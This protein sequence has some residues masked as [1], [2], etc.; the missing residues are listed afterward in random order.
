MSTQ[1]DDQRAGLRSGLTS[2]LEACM[3]LNEMGFVE[4]SQGDHPS[5]VFLS[6]Y[7]YAKN[8]PYQELLYCR[9][10]E[11][12][13]TSLPLLNLED[14]EAFQWPGHMVLHLHWLNKVLDGCET[15]ESANH[16]TDAFIAQLRR[17]R[18]LGYHIIWSIHNVH[19]H[20]AKHPE[21]ESL[22]GQRMANE[23]DTVHVLNWNTLKE[24]EAYYT[25]DADKVV[26]SPIPS[27]LGVYP[28]RTNVHRSRA[29]LG[30]SVSDLVF[31]LFGSLMRYKGTMEFIEAVDALKERGSLQNAK[32]VVAGPPTDKALSEALI[33]RYSERTDVL[34]FV[35]QIRADDVQNF[36]RAADF[37]ACPYLKSLNSSVA[38]VALTF[39]RRVL[40]PHRGC[41]VELAEAFP[42]AVLTYLPENPLGLPEA[43]E[44]AAAAQGHCDERAFEGLEQYSP[45]RVS[46]SFL[47][48]IRNRLTGGAT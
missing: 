20:D 2:A 32:V 12:G 19:P 11:S 48:A 13:F 21:Y 28:D 42:K 17:L 23:V 36:L 24:T 37:V 3:T 14:A 46:V 33:D 5:P 40:A 9:A 10:L 18:L 38:M 16:R 30:L 6:Y 39:K 1:L 34:L 27:Y 8:N 4:P 29:A 31:V 45:E 35:Q 22:L 47:S 25:I 41:F 44:R 26:H 15:L 43:L 7:P